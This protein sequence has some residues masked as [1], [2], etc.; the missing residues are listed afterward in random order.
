[1]KQI[2]VE[3]PSVAKVEDAKLDA[4]VDGVFKTSA[5]IIVAEIKKFVHS[6]VVKKVYCISNF[7]SDI[8][9]FR[10]LVCLLL[11]TRKDCLLRCAPPPLPRK[12]KRI[13]LVVR[14]TG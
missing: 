7:N 5:F 6:V 2:P 12:G 3:I 8:Y 1:M 9:H 10:I 4:Y 14:E 11:I 13:G